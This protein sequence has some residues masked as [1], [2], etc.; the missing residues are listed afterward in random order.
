ML[1][2]R[3][4]LGME[5]W[6]ARS[7]AG[8]RPFDLARHARLY[9]VGEGGATTWRSNCSMRFPGVESGIELTSASLIGLAR[10]HQAAPSCL[11]PRQTRDR[12]GGVLPS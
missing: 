7:Y 9:E 4:Y 8:R 5:R 11:K 10:V 6:R 2:V 12:R 1:N 3:R